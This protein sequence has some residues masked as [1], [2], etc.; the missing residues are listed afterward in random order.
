[1][2]KLTLC[3]DGYDISDQVFTIEI[4]GL[5]EI[6]VFIN[7]IKNGGVSS[8]LIKPAVIIDS[9]GKEQTVSHRNDWQID[10]SKL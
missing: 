5:N 7:L 4:D 1:M 8:G 9:N 6:S 3:S 10:E 2:A